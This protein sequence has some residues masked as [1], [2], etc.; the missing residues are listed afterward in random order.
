[1]TQALLKGMQ[2]KADFDKNKQI[3]VIELFKY[4]YQDVTSRADDV[5]RLSGDTDK[6]HP[7]LITSKRCHSMVVTTW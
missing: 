6:Q 5:D 1:M 4:I 7:Q 2:G 3:T